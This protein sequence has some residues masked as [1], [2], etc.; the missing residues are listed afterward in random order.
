MA[1]FAGI[2]V[3]IAVTTESYQ[4]SGCA[5]Y[6]HHWTTEGSTTQQRHDRDINN[7]VIFT[8]AHTLLWYICAAHFGML[9]QCFRTATDNFRSL[10]PQS[11]RL[12]GALTLLFDSNRAIF[13]Y[14]SGFLLKIRGGMSSAHAESTVKVSTVRCNTNVFIRNIGQSLGF[15]PQDDKVK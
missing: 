13:D 1:L 10:N 12:A 3:D 5:N 11:F 6:L 14:H 7:A 4:V 2:L 8:R 15:R 9:R